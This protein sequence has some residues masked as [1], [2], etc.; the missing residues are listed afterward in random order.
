VSQYC[1]DGLLVLNGR[2]NSDE[3]VVSGNSFHD[4]NAGIGAVWVAGDGNSIIDNDF[5]ESGVPGWDPA[6][7]AVFL[8]YSPDFEAINTLVIESGNFPQGT[9]GAKNHVFDGALEWS[10]ESAPCPTTN[11]V[12]GHQVGDHSGDPGIG[13]SLQDLRYLLDEY[14]KEELELLENSVRR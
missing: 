4:V 9:G 13:Q 3:C 5:R 8:N 12:V 6:I 10:C 7:G 2:N 11:R 1:V 14:S